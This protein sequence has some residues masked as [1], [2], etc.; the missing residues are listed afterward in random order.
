MFKYEQKK[1]SAV[2]I[3]D[4]VGRFNQKRKKIFVQKFEYFD[5]SIF[6]VATLFS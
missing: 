2:D 3:V 1:Y 5:S 4:I 6:F